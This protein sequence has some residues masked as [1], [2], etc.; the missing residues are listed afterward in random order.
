MTENSRVEATRVILILMGVSGTGKT[1][2]G[3]ML[4]AETGW[5]FLDGDDFHPAAN[6]AKMA[7]GVPLTDEDRAPWLATLHGKIEEYAT[8]CNSMILACSALR[9]Q[10]RT[11]LRGDLSPDEVRFALLEADPAVI[12]AHLQGRHHEFMNPHLLNSQLATLE[13]PGDEAWHIS[14]AGTP[15]ESMALLEG[16]LRDAGALI[17]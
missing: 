15:Q 17:A 9:T 11:V 13:A 1:T 16:R 10:Y 2:L 12:A 3:E 14:V 6:K 7:S 5:P 4:S 8:A